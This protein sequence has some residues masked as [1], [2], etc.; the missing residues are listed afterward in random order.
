MELSAV[1]LTEGLSF[2]D[3]KPDNPSV[4]TFGFA[5]SPYTGEAFI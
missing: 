4:K 2:A 3:H 5:A 1:K